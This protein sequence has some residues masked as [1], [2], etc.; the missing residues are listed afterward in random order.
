[1]L[2]R[3]MLPAS[4]LHLLHKERGPACSDGS[5]PP[6]ARRIQRN[7]SR[8]EM[9]H[10]IKQRYVSAV[11]KSGLH[12]TPRQSSKLPTAHNSF[13][14]GSQFWNTAV[15]VLSKYDWFLSPREGQPAEHN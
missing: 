11:R 15:L 5:K 13:A 6:T 3:Y 8:V 4:W 9:K 7:T 2:D 10:L 14:H 1:M 12:A